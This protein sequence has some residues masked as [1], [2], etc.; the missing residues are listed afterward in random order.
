MLPSPTIRGQPILPRYLDTREI[1]MRGDSPNEIRQRWSIP[2]QRRHDIDKSLHINSITGYLQQ[3]LYE[4]Q[5]LFIHRRCLGCQLRFAVA[6]FGR[7]LGHF[8]IG[9]EIG[10]VHDHQG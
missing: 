2:S 9:R 4:T 7:R 10:N 3:S 1:P 5:S 8:R 6:Y